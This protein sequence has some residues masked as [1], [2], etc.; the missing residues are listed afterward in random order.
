MNNE[1]RR[2]EKVRK[3]ENEKRFNM[4]LNNN[5]FNDFNYYQ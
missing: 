4:Y 2:R 3:I 5:V 1:Y